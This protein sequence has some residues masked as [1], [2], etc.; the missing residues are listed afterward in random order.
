MSWSECCGCAM[1]FYAACQRNM[2]AQYCCGSGST[3]K[4]FFMCFLHRQEANEVILN[5][6]LY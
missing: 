3:N 2:M 5:V 4:Q 1:A 6:W